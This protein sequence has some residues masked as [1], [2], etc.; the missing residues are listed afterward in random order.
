MVKLP[1]DS[2]V[3]DINIYSYLL[4]N[5][6]EL[7]GLVLICFKIRHVKD[8]LSIHK[9]LLWISGIWILCSFCYFSLFSIENYF[10]GSLDSNIV[11]SFIFFFIQFRNI[12][13][14]AISTIFCTIVVSSPN[15]V[16][17]AENPTSLTTLLDFEL[18]MMSVVPYSYFK[19]FVDKVKQDSE[20]TPQYMYPVFL[21]LYTKIEM[22]FDKKH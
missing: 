15:L 10:P 9:E 18:V 21:K 6:I 8:E 13:T 1:N 19:R 17:S 22:L 12:S 11:S 7:V 14:V 4:L 20:E 16:Y 5:W 2:S 3:F